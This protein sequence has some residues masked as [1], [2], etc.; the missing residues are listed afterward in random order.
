MGRLSTTE[1]THPANHLPCC[2]GSVFQHQNLQDFIKTVRALIKDIF[3]TTV[4]DDLYLRSQ[5]LRCLIYCDV[6]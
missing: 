2:F 1:G 4:V 3:L 5:G 6:S